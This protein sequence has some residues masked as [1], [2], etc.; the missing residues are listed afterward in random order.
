MKNFLRHFQKYAIC[1]KE[2]KG[3]FK[4]YFLTFFIAYL[5]LAG[6]SMPTFGIINLIV[7][8]IYYFIMR[9][10]ELIGYYKING[11][12]FYTDETTVIDTIEFGYRQDNQENI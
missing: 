11:L 8:A 4:S 2:F 5:L 10:I 7:P 9:T 6:L 3:F 1:K 12:C